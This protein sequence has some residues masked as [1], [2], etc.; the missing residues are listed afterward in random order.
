MVDLVKLIELVKC[1]LSVKIVKSVQLGYIV[2]ELVKFV[3]F[4]YFR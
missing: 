4:T 3:S 2:R 1:V